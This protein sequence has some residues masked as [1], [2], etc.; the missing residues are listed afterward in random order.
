MVKY[1]Y[2]GE[3]IIL[4]PGEKICPTCEGHG[5]AQYPHE[6]S[7]ERLESDENMYE[8]PCLVCHGSGKVDWITNCMK[9]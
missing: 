4:E 2:W 8:T 7:F 9:G 6:T 3:P 1:T 5:V